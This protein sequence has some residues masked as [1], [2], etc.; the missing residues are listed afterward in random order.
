MAWWFPIVRAFNEGL[1]RPRV[2]RAQGIARPFFFSSIPFPRIEGR[3]QGCP[4]LRASDEHILIVRVLRAT[5]A[6][7][8]SLLLFYEPVLA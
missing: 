3:G 5:R 2:A 8:C 4:R 7:G 1:L 6:P